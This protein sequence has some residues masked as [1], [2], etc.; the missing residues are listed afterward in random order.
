MSPNNPVKKLTPTESDLD[1]QGEQSGE[2][3]REKVAKNLHGPDANPSQLGDPISLK[4][5]TSDRLPT[6]D[7][8]GSQSPSPSAARS[9]DQGGD[10]LR[11]KAMKKLHGPDANPSM[12]GDPI[13][14]KN[15]STDN[16][17]A[18]VEEKSMSRR[19]S[20]L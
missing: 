10:T 8:K 18:E 12:L 11:E 6:E 20:K 16:L 4:N 2:T 13:S 9:K 3:L 17:P 5:E 1:N 7:E 15:E 14:M 19:D